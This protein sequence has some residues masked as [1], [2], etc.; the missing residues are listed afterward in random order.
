MKR[1]QFYAERLKMGLSWIINTS[2]N[3]CGK[4]CKTKTGQPQQLFFNALS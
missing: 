3:P 1:N 4:D 2:N